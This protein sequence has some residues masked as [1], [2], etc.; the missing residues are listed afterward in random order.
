MI[1]GSTGPPLPSIYHIKISLP[2]ETRKKISRAYKYTH[3]AQSSN[4][5]RQPIYLNYK[6]RTAYHANI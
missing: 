5:K 2:V 3:N 1:H 4:K 6:K